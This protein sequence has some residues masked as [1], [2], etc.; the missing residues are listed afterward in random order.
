LTELPEHL[1]DGSLKLVCADLPAT[2]I[3]VIDTQAFTNIPEGE[4]QRG[5]H[6]SL[7]EDK[8]DNLCPLLLNIALGESAGV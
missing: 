1:L 4:D 8:V 3:L 6:G 7:R 5:F 2:Q